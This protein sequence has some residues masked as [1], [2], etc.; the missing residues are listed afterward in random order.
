MVGAPA[1][2]CAGEVPNCLG[3]VGNRAIPGVRAEDDRRRPAPAH[4]LPS[5]RLFAPRGAARARGRRPEEQRRLAV[6]ADGEQLDEA[7]DGLRVAQAELHRVLLVEL[8]RAL[9]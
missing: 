5:M 8:Q 9:R 1:A 4:S 6:L 2:P 3:L 7:R